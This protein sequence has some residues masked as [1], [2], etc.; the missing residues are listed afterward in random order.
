MCAFIRNML[1]TSRTSEKEIESQNNL[2]LCFEGLPH[3]CMYLPCEVVFTFSSPDSIFV[4]N[5]LNWI[6]TRW[7]GKTWTGF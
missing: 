6:C 7:I 4:K 1:Y 5:G 3:D 2:G